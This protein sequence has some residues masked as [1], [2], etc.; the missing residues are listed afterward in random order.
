MNPDD[1]NKDKESRTHVSAGSQGTMA[2]TVDRFARRVVD[3]L[4]QWADEDEIREFAAEFEGVPIKNVTV[5]GDEIMIVAV[6][7]R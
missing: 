2:I 5:I 6:Q 4:V 3:W 7:Q 1:P